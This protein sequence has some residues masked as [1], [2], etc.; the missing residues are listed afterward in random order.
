MKVCMLPIL[1]I[2]KFISMLNQDD[3]KFNLDIKAE[4][5]DFNLDRLQPPDPM[6]AFSGADWK[7][8]PYN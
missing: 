7:L 8:N 6:H 2:S 3:F 1:Q 5:S 4:V